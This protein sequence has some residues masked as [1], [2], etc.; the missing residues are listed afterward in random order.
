MALNAMSGK[1]SLQVRIPSA[2]HL[3][4]GLSRHRGHAEKKTCLNHKDPS[5]FQSNAHCQI[6][7][8]IFPDM[9]RIANME[10][11]LEELLFRTR[12][13]FFG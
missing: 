1:Q 3:V 12:N 10:T 11:P 13:V 8:S 5:V 6:Q 9:E 7:S 2:P 4:L